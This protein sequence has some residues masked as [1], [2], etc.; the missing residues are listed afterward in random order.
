MIDWSP[1]TVGRSI[2]VRVL[3]AMA[4]CGLLPRFASGAIPAT[5]LACR[6]E[7]REAGTVGAAAGGFRLGSAAAPFGWA[8]AVA[9]FD[10][11]GLADF[12]VVDRAVS[13]EPQQ[14]YVVEIAVSS[15]P[16]QRFVLSF[17]HEAVTVVVEDIDHDDDLDVVATH[18][19]TREVLAAW[20]NDGFGRFTPTLRSVPTRL[21]PHDGLAGDDSV[22]SPPPAVAGDR[23]LPC[24]NASARRTPDDDTARNAVLEAG[25]CR[26][27][28]VFHARIDS[29]G[30]PALA[31]L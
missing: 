22:A 25:A 6:S 13:V 1:G 23:V 27:R 14:H 20:A 11:D 31:L 30:P 3:C 19:L 26:A 5:E 15:L 12:A 29:R 8:T 28:T 9:D 7:I 16:K 10:H 17:P 2:A 4:A 18:P 21:V 24:G